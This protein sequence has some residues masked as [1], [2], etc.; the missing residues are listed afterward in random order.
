MK[1]G[2]S[3]C[4][5]RDMFFIKILEYQHVLTLSATKI[6][7]FSNL[8]GIMS[9]PAENVKVRVVWINKRTGD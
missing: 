8:Q 1:T 4:V 3:L 5:V 2:N 6:T 9:L 7:Y